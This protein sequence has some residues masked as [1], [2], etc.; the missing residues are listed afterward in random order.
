MFFYSAGLKYHDTTVNNRDNIAGNISFRKL[1]LATCENPASNM[2]KKNPAQ[3]HSFSKGNLG[4]GNAIIPEIVQTFFT[5]LTA[6][7]FRVSF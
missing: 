6:I 2:I 3:I 4:I 1:P 5:C 7:I